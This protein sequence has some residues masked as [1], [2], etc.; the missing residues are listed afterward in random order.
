MMDMI[1]VL[2][3]LAMSMPLCMVPQR[4]PKP[5]VK[6]PMA[7]TDSWGA[8]AARS[9]AVRRLLYSSAVARCVPRSEAGRKS[10][11]D[12]TVGVEDICVWAASWATR[13]LSVSSLVS[14]AAVAAAP[15]TETAEEV[16]ATIAMRLLIDLPGLRWAPALRRVMVCV[17]FVPLASCDLLVTL[18]L[19]DCPEAAKRNHV[20]MQRV[21]R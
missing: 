9:A 2:V 12:R 20:V 4:G 15:E 14:A 18:G 21:Q 5:E 10:R 19:C 17:T 16:R 6:A 3:T 8:R 1:G 7:G 11:T 13:S